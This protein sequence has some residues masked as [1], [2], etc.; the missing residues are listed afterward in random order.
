M[1]A[2]VGV[3]PGGYP[4]AVATLILRPTAGGT[5]M[6]SGERANES[7]FQRATVVALPRMLYHCWNVKKC[8][9]QHVHASYSSAL[10][11]SD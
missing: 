8:L 1:G 10:G 4:A 6:P 7:M 3:V 2:V 9:K 11:K 5:S